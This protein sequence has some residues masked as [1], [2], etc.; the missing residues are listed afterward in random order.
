MKSNDLEEKRK[1]REYDNYINDLKLILSQLSNC[2]S[3]LKTQDG[4]KVLREKIEEIDNLI[5]TNNKYNERGE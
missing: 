5:K 1:Q 4:V 3:D 2:Y